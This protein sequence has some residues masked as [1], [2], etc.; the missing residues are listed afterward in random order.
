MNQPAT[1]RHRPRGSQEHGAQTRESSSRSRGR[2]TRDETRQ[3]VVRDHEAARQ[4][5]L[6]QRL[7]NSAVAAVNSVFRRNAPPS[8]P[9]ANRLRDG[10][11]SAEPAAAQRPTGVS[12][13]P[14]QSLNVG[15][16]GA[17]A[18]APLNSGSVKVVPIESARR[19]L[20]GAEEAAAPERKAG[21]TLD[22]KGTKQ[23]M[24]QVE[25]PRMA[26]ARK[27]QFTEPEE[28]PAFDRRR[29]TGLTLN[30]RELVAAVRA[31][32]LMGVLAPKVK[33]EQQAAA[34][35]VSAG[36]MTRDYQEHLRWIGGG[37]SGV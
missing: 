25:M 29:L 16:E 1:P 20:D 10:L 22:L 31:L 34:K 18:E 9:L 30:D 11:R 2:R 12:T 23:L 13:S 36:T 24:A 15:S 26:A 21:N 19:G 33:F 35:G 17:L 6:S 28:A 4:Q 5:G 7:R 37:S 3:A 14:S 32:E 8:Q 27:I